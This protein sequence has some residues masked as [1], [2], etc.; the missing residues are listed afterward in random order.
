MIVVKKKVG[1]SQSLENGKY[2]QDNLL[3][4]KTNHL[5]LRVDLDCRL[6]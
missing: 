3:F 2:P 5:Y 6:L 1:R 4:E